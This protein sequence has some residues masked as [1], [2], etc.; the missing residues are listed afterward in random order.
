[1]IHFG[2]GDDRRNSKIAAK[3]IRHQKFAFCTTDLSQTR[4]KQYMDA[5]QKLR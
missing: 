2:E 5:T 3:R 1:M 4:N